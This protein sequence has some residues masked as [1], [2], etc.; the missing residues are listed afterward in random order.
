MHIKLCSADQLCIANSLQVTRLHSK[1]GNTFALYAFL[2][3]LKV[4]AFD[5]IYDHNL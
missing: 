4:R 1:R 2:Q 3:K 5:Y